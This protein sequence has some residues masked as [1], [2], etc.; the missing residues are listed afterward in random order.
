MN[1]ILYLDTD[2]EKRKEIMTLRNQKEGEQII[3]VC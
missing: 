2:Y 3:M 1:Q